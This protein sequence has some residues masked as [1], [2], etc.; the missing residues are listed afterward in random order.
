MPP[1]L[2]TLHLLCGKI[3]SGKST[4]SAKL[5]DLTETVVIA[6]DDWLASLYSEQMS[7]VSDYIRCSTKLQKIMKP[8]VVSLLKAGMSV[9]LDFPANTIASRKWMREIIEAANAKHQLHYLNVPD[10]ICKERL[11]KRNRIGDHA[12]AATDEQFIQISKHFVAP[13]SEE[14]FNIILHQPN[15][16]P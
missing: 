12:F 11:R 15:D 2:P 7:S 10:E 16:T 3:A 14:G 4:L 6:E 5:G 9:V 8:H 1:N 13:S